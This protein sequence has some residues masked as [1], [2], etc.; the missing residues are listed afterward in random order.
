MIYLIRSWGRGGKSILKVGYTSNLSKRME[1]YYHSNPFFEKI[2]SREGS[3][4][5]EKKLQLYLEALGFKYKIL[6]EWFIDSQD[7][8]LKFHS[9]I[10][11]I[12]RI[13]WKNR[14]DLF[15]KEDFKNGADI[16]MRQIYEELLEIY[17]G[18]LNLEI[19]K[20]YKSIKN[21]EIIKLLR[22]EDNFFFSDER[23]NML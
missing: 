12:N 15:K 10:S 22:E 19:D 6:D 4:I 2:S 17:K 9:S 21:L 3:L 14:S 7:I 13:I 23:F 18:K 16:R 1:N 20:E 11:E 5:E 8:I